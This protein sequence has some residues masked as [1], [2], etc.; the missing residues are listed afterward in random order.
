MRNFLLE[1]YFSLKNLKTI[2]RKRKKSNKYASINIVFLFKQ[3]L[4]FHS[5]LFTIIKKNT[6]QF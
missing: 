5:D 1:N 3:I 2:F 6:F 4:F